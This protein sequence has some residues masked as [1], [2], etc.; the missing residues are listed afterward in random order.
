MWPY[1]NQTCKS[2]VPSDTSLSYFLY[3]RCFRLSLAA[4]LLRVLRS[5]SLV[6]SKW[7]VSKNLFMKKISSIA[8]VQGICLRTLEREKERV[9]LRGIKENEHK[10]K[11]TQDNRKTNEKIQAFGWIQTHN[12]LLSDQLYLNAVLYTCC[13]S[14]L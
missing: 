11:E 9:W 12:Y 5:L 6:R 4:C 14:S 3:L 1:L 10:R 7:C 13:P 8:L 2:K